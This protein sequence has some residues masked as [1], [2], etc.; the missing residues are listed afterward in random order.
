M[1]PNQLT[2]V[3]VAAE[4]L[5]A[6]IGRLEDVLGVNKAWP[7]TQHCL[8]AYMACKACEGDRYHDV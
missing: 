5:R 7:I 6:I 1:T 3:W 4:D 2:T 8:E